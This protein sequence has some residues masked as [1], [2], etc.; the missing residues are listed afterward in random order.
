MAN[1]KSDLKKWAKEHM[2]GVENT[3]FP[4]FTPDMKGLDEEGI[5]LDVRQS[6][7]H[8][9]FSTMCATETGLSLEESKRF[10]EI[11]ADEADGKIL[12]TTSLI[13]NSF[14]EHM[15]LAEHAEKVGLNGVL[16][17]YPTTF[18]PTD[19]EEVY[20]VTKD[21]CESTNMHVTLY[22]SPH[23]PFGKFHNSGFPLDVMARLAELP[24][25][26]A[27]KIGEMGLYAD[28]QRMIGDKV[29]IGCPVE[30]F[31][32]LLI[33]GFGMQWMGAGCYEVFQ[34]PE[35]PYL[36]E[37]FNLLLEG[38]YDAA[39]EIYWKIAPM[40]NIFEQQFNVTVMTGTYN[41]HQQKFYQWCT[42]GNGG[43]TRQPAMK[44]HQWE[45][46]PIKMGYFLI[47]IETPEND[48]EFFMG[49]MNYARL[50]ANKKEAE[51]SKIV[52]PDVSG[53]TIES[54]SED[55]NEKAIRLGREFFNVLIDM[56]KEIKQIPVMIR[57]MVKS[58]F[59]KKTGASISDWCKKA[60]VLVNKIEKETTLSGFDELSKDLLPRL[61]Q[62]FKNAPEES[63]R[64]IKDED[65]LQ[66][67]ASKMANREATVNALIAFLD[68]Q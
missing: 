14:E 66:T 52:A 50:H 34:S 24:N 39:M 11:A 35:K 19:K 65:Q 46:D 59:T 1:S 48:D 27:V 26:V 10:V 32:P 38:K 51:G 42:G 9:F 47:D 67:L 37:Y 64:R 4:S 31:V 40:R 20:K 17:G 45:A 36:V 33:R 55:D 12:V 49:K 5:R 16:L 54:D 56:E 44:L 23:F 13:L 7:A 18:H 2:K 57:P 28:V 21:F 41:W 61:S 58:D 25:V 22:P 15:E 30:R 53:D 62:Y 43:L 3:L 8:G 63:R 29:L 6:I 60:E 68:K